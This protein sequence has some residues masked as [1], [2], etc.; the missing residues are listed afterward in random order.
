MT[1]KLFW[2]FIA[3]F[4]VA[5]ASF[6]V[7]EDNFDDDTFDVDDDN[8]N[9]ERQGKILFPFVSI[10]R[11]ANVDCA[12]TNTMNGTCLA[13][14]ECN[15]LN[16]TITGSCAARRGRCCIVSR[17]CGTATNVNNTYFTSPGYPA[18]YAGGQA[19]SIIVNRCNDNICQLRIDLLDMVLAQPN[20]DGVCATDALTIT[21]GNTIVPIL[22]GDNTG[23]T[24]F[25]D[26]NGNAAITISVTA[27]L[28]TT[29]TRR[30][31]IRL[32]QLGCDCPGLAPNGCL[33]YYTGITGTITSFNY[34][35]AANTAL[36][37]SL[38]TGT[39]QLANLNYG[40]CI[41][42]EAGYCAIQ[43][44]QTANDVFSFTVTGDVE[45]AD[46]T[47]LGTPIGAVNGAACTT[48]FVV[49]PNPIV[50]GTNL[51]AGTDRF[52]GLGFVPVQSGAKPFVLYVVTDANEGATAT[53]P[54][55]IA[56]R[57]FSLAYT[58]IAC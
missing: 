35:T 41:R 54:P 15:N 43:Y 36:S 3:T 4:L 32:T 14:R 13:R 23:Q 51:G 40:I 38:V 48:D 20:G 47:V 50:V 25:V 21:G 26:F 37:A 17:S 58:Q 11:F 30:W 8:N 12:S 22:C 7:Y 6:T 42:M 34:G 57:G 45:G 16:G 31:N 53:T 52:C 29:F 1:E 5:V 18:A 56:N 39:R 49:I 2:I 27:T 44:A 10:V 46:N 55:D 28:A 19:C 24:L 9:G 33:Q